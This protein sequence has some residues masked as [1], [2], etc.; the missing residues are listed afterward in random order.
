MIDNCYDIDLIS[1]STVD[2]KIVRALR[3]KISIAD[4][5]L[6]KADEVLLES[7]NEL[8]LLGVIQCRNQNLSCCD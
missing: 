5:I 4:Q 8:L 1:P 3:D 7:E 2:E 6:W